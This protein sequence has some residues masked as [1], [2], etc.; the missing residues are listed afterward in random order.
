VVDSPDLRAPG[1]SPVKTT[2]SRLS[3]TDRDSV[4][5]PEDTI[6]VSSDDEASSDNVYS[7]DPCS[8]DFN[9]PFWRLSYDFQPSD[10]STGWSDMRE[11]HSECLVKHYWQLDKVAEAD[12]RYMDLDSQRI[13][14][15]RQSEVFEGQPDELDGQLVDLDQSKEFDDQPEEL[16]DQPE[17][18]EEHSEEFEAFPE[19]FHYETKEFEDQ[20]EDLAED[21]REELD[22]KYDEA[23]DQ[24]HRL[25]FYVRSHD[26]QSG[27]YFLL[28]LT[29][30]QKFWSYLI[31]QRIGLFTCHQYHYYLSS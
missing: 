28:L 11:S 27:E 29:F 18:F 12:E 16:E 26:S 13:G 23:G 1:I 3:V 25:P 19:E 21:Q 15:H 8:F 17:D 9:R 6:I 2:L 24:H 20:L 10:E 4:P 7:D 14:L 31:L 5:D 30:R 22:D